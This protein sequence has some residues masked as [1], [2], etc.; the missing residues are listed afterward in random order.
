MPLSVSRGH[1]DHNARF[2]ASTKVDTAHMSIQPAPHLQ[3]ISGMAPSVNCHKSTGACSRLSS[4]V[5]ASSY[6]LSNRQAAPLGEG[7]VNA[8]VP[9]NG[10]VP[11]L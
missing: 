10:A 11:P 6:T 7:A 9:E 8:A 3:A 4:D 5:Y 1:L 2:D